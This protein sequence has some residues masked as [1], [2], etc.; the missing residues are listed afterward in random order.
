MNNQI[1]PSHQIILLRK[2]SCGSGDA[3]A[4]YQY[5]I[6]EAAELAGVTRRVWLRYWRW[7]LANSDGGLNPDQRHFDGEAIYRVRRAEQIRKQMETDLRA[8]ATIV[9]LLERVDRLERELDFYR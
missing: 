9:Q 3:S 1:P 8:A 6:D 7:G 5:V 4:S 2:T